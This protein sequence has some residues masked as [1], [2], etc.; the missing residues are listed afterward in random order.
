MHS[1]EFRV[2]DEWMRHFQTSLKRFVHQIGQDSQMEIV[3][4][5]ID[6]MLKLD[7]SI[8]VAGTDLM[9]GLVA[10]SVSQSNVS[11]DL[12]S[13]WEAELLQ[14]MLQEFLH[15]PAE[16]EVID[17]PDTEQLRILSGFLEANKDLGERFSAELQVINSQKAKE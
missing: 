15:T 2:E 8:S 10:D 6:E 9:D 5:R 4:Q 7:L 14:E 16:D 13:Q 12:V 3:A 17:A 1:S 11:S